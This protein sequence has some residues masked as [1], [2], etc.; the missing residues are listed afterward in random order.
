MC[1]DPFP[2]KSIDFEKTNWFGRSHWI[3]RVSGIILGRVLCLVDGKHVEIF[4]L[5]KTNSDDGV[6][7][8]FFQE[9]TRP[10]NSGGPIC[11]WWC[12]THKHMILVMLDISQ[13]PSKRLAN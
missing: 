9:I 8:V 13:T 7:V 11:V 4:D 12:Q 5:V 3:E 2:I 1:F 10:W 6:A